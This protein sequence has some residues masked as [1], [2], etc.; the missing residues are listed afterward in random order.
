[1]MPNNVN[2]ILM[3]Y[4]LQSCL[5]TG[6]VTRVTRRASLVEQELLPLLEHLNSPPYLNGIHVTRTLILCV[7]FVCRCLYF[8]SW[9]LPSLSFYWWFWLHLWSLQTLLV[10][11]ILLLI[12]KEANDDNI[13]TMLYLWNEIYNLR[14]QLNEVKQTPTVPFNDKYG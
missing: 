4:N 13:M 8:L 6:F 7:C 1:M 11:Y 10:L 14:N 5:N 2:V 9:P 3:K 12:Y